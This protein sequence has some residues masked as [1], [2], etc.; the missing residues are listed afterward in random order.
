MGVQLMN[1][2]GAAEPLRNRTAVWNR[3]EP[4]TL[5]PEPRFGV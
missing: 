5:E 1:R 3:K 4:E 2:A